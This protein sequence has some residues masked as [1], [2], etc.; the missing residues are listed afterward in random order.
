MIAPGPQLDPRPEMFAGF[1]RWLIEPLG[2]DSSIALFERL[3]RLE[4]AGDVLPLTDR[5]FLYPWVFPI[6]REDVHEAL[7]VGLREVEND[8]LSDWV[9]EEVA[10]HKPGQYVLA[11][12]QAELNAVPRELNAQ[13]RFLAERLTRTALR[14][15]PSEPCQEEQ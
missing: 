2:K 5:E 15:P 7:Q 6:V 10:R 12:V 9:K 3:Q 13:C 1:L 14:L 11:S 4:H 8:Y